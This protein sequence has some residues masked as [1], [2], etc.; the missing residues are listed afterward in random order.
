MSPMRNLAAL[1]CIAAFGWA[2]NW[3]QFRGPSAVGIGDGL[4]PP[5]SFDAVRSANIAWKTRIP[6][7]GHCKSGP[8]GRPALCNHRHQQQSQRRV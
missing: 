3:P 7:L 6:G 4:N 8:L 2:Q 1:F 5:I